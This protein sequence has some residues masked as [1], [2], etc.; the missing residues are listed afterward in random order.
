MTPHEDPPAWLMDGPPAWLTEDVPDIDEGPPVLRILAPDE[1]P[2]GP[3]PDGAVWAQLAK[4]VRRDKDGNITAEIPKPNALNFRLIVTFDPRWRGRL[5]W[6]AMAGHYLF[7]DDRKGVVRPLRDDDLVELQLWVSSV[8]G[9]DVGWADVCR[10]ADLVCRESPRHELRDWLQGLTW[11]GV[12]RL[13]GL[14]TTYFGCEE[15]E[16]AGHY[17]Q[18]W[19]IQAVARIMRPGCEA[20][21]MV[22]LVGAQGRGKTRGVHA[23]AGVASDGRRYSVDLP[24]DRP[25]GDRDSKMAMRVGWIVNA[26]EME[27]INRSGIAAV[28]AWITETEDTFRAPYAKLPETYRRQQVL[29]GSTNRKSFLADSTGSRRFW[30][31]ELVRDV[32]VPAIARDREQLWAE[33]MALYRGGIRWWL[34]RE[35]QHALAQV[36]DG[37]RVD[38]WYE[39]E[40]AAIVAVATQRQSPIFVEDILE[41]LRQTRDMRLD[42]Q[43]AGAKAKATLEHLGCVWSGRRKRAHPRSGMSRRFYMPPEVKP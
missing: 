12:E 17:G 32:D 8:Y 9:L 33:A 23:L 43:V 21:G 1:A 29:I 31:L 35:Q 34:D 19:A 2:P 3:R 24:V 18:M 42:A 30:V 41:E 39:A 27:A 26:D 22:V 6:D 38:G 36:N 5:G 28:K 10:V 15:H 25:V 40:I 11:D 37:Y 14:W 16:M 13:H 7:A 20:Q 4:V